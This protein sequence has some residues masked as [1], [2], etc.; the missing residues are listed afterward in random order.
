[1]LNKVFRLLLIAGFVSIFLVASRKTNKVKT[2]SG[3]PR[4]VSAEF[5]TVVSDH[6]LEE[7]CSEKVFLTNMR[8]CLMTGQAVDGLSPLSVGMDKDYSTMAVT[9]FQP[10]N[11]PIR[12]I[13][14]RD[15]LEATFNRVVK[16]IRE[17][18]RFASFDID[19]KDKCRIMLE[20]IDG[21]YPLKLTQMNTERFDDYR[22]EPGITGLKMIHDGRTHYYMPTDA[23]VKSHMT[24]RQVLN[25][26]ARRMRVAT[27]TNKKSERV[28]TM[29]GLDAE[30][31]L[32]TSKAFITYRDDVLELY[33]GYPMPV[34]YCGDKAFEMVVKSS[35]WILTNMYDDGR[36]MYYYE[37]LENSLIDYMHPNRTLENNYYNILRH[38]GGIIALL[39]M[40]EYNGDEKYIPGAQRAIE[41]LLKQMKFHEY[42]GRKA[43]YI[44]YNQKSKLGGSGIALVALMRYYELTGDTQYNKYAEYLANHLLSRIDSKGEMLGY[45]I[46]PQYNEGRPILNPTEEEVKALFSFYYPG[47]ALMGLALYY[48]ALSIETAETNRIRSMSKKA[49]DFLI[50][51]RPKKYPE[52]FKPLPSDGW[53]MQAIEEW[54]DVDGFCRQEYFNFVFD[55]ASKM[56]QHMYTSDDK[57]YLDYPGAFYYDFGDH[58]YIDG[59]RAEGLIAAYYLAQNLGGTQSEKFLDACK[60]VARS[61][62]H[63][64]NSEKSSYMHYD[65]QKSIGSF[66]F[67]Y[68]RQWARV[69]VAQHSSC[70]LI[71]LLAACD[72]E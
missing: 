62:M 3:Q 25:Y 46:H 27:H 38:S 22:F 56:I 29:L 20:I 1:M 50:F 30:A 43:G 72:K 39:R 18:S 58:G 63:S 37:P 68:T 51:D 6:A 70:F 14:K 23:M 31:Y 41:Y 8:K 4:P 28:T 42:D 52:M 36:F 65:P 26:L 16:K 10:G 49:M 48:K 2:A 15:T 64:Y 59:A 61:I 7:S 71:R 17:N 57:S 21:Q 47:E 13:T 60:V 33:R 55:D 9:L 45:Y 69:D 66:R 67:K 54:S 35:D 32:I 19:D 34:E 5:S 11:K 44:Y 24:P 53:L 12:W 40:Y